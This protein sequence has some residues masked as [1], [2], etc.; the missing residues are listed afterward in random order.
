VLN[1]TDNTVPEVTS[2]E[3]ESELAMQMAVIA[4]EIVIEQASM[5][6]RSTICLW[7]SRPINVIPKPTDI[8]RFFIL[9]KKNMCLIIADNLNVDSFSIKLV[10]FCK[11]AILQ[12]HWLLKKISLAQQRIM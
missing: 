2:S 7:V 8:F 11:K 10:I 6:G 3:P 9:N 4:L 1:G 5:Q 12:Q